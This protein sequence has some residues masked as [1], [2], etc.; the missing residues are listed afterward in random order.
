MSY[1]LDALRRAERER[2]LGQAPTVQSLAQ[3]AAPQHPGPA[4]RWLRPAIVATMLVLL[5]GSA[6]LLLSRPHGEGAAPTT[7]PAVVHTPPPLPAE[8]A[9]PAAVESTAAATVIDEDVA[10]E[11]LD[12]VTPTF[13]AGGE[14]AA[15]P[16]PPA[17]PVAEEMSTPAPE[18]VAR[19]PATVEPPPMPAAR[20][21]A[22]LPRTLREMPAPYRAG[23]PAVTLDVHVYDAEPSRRWVMVGG[24]RYNEGETLASGP[25]IIAVVP[26]G[27]IAEHAGE[28][29]LL[30]LNR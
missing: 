8:R 3:A 6:W 24:R 30:P 18:P 19:I 28:R 2:H 9:L 26:E 5:A 1:I 10:V 22:G 25:R 27:V 7:A 12:D 17:R 20:P 23:F 11:S 4:R 14:T 29:V 15:A 13:T 21:D 16:A